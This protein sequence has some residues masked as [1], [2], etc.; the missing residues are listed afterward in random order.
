MNVCEALGVEVVKCNCHRVNSAVLWSLGIS[1]AAASCKNEAMGE[2]MKLAACIG[3]FSHSA[4]NNDMLK[5]FQKLWRRTS[6][7]YTSSSGETTRSDLYFEFCV[8]IVFVHLELSGIRLCCS[9]N[10][11][12]NFVFL[13]SVFVFQSLIVKYSFCFFRCYVISEIETFSLQIRRVSAAFDTVLTFGVPLASF[14]FHRIN[15]Y[16]KIPNLKNRHLRLLPRRPPP[17]PPP[18]HNFSP[19]ET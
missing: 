7:V 3:V 5:E 2:L 10:A 12:N 8:C 14:D 11:R 4:V 16:M 17:L 15:K 6:T 19:C 1:G 13:F 18:P 9:C